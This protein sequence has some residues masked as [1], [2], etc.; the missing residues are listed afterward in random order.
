[1]VVNSYGPVQ[2]GIP[3]GGDKLGEKFLRKNLA[4]EVRPQLHWQQVC[5]GRA[6]ERECV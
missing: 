2:R 3:E 4:S 1:M 5:E 6:G